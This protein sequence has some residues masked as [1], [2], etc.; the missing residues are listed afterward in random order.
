ML[1]S[2]LSHTPQKYYEADKGDNPV[3]DTSTGNDPVITE[4]TF[5][6]SEVDEIIKDRL[7][8]AKRK[9][10]D[11]AQAAKTA[12]EQKALLEQ[13]EYK[14]LA[15]QRAAE[16]ATAQ[17]A[18]EAA[19]AHKEAAE[20]YKTALLSRL[21]VDKKSL[22]AGIVA[23]IDKLDPIDQVAWFSDPKNAELLKPASPSNP[24]YGTPP[25]NGSNAGRKTDA[26][27]RQSSDDVDRPRHT[28][29]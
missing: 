2:F 23:L 1:R 15:E 22:P 16:L 9:A 4:K 11:E 24:A 3:G 6:Q 5:K 17:T 29:G 18:L 25:R 13:G 20:Q 26:P 27:A 12:A 14:T 10:D 7:A 21:A 19:N 28:L 8:R